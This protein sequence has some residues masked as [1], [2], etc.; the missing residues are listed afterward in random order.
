MLGNFVTIGVE[1]HLHQYWESN[2][3]PLDAY[4]VIRVSWTV[5]YGIVSTDYMLLIG[6]TGNH[7]TYALKFAL[8]L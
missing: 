1:H 3:Q 7:I 2:Q 4:L 8:N 6:F 5:L